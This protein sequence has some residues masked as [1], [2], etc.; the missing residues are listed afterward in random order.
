MTNK[1]MRPAAVKRL[2]LLVLFFCVLLP[3]ERI[4]PETTSVQDGWVT[5]TPPEFKDAINNPLKGF[6]DYKPNGYGL[7]ERQYIRW[8]EIETGADESVD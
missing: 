3:A 1:K 8:N 2:P 6:R 7:V 4:H 5:V